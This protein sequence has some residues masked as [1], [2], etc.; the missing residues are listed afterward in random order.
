[1]DKR[2]KSMLKQ[3]L[4]NLVNWNIINFHEF[5]HINKSIEMEY[6]QK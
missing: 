1:M 2:E 3:S 5:E 4:A 6:N